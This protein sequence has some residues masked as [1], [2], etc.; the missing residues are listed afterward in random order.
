MN[1]GTVGML[2]TRCRRQRPPHCDPHR[3]LINV[4]PVWP[5]LI[6]DRSDPGTGHGA[7]GWDTTVLTPLRA[8]QPLDNVTPAGPRKGRNM[9]Q[10][11]TDL[12]T[13]GGACADQL[14]TRPGRSPAGRSIYASQQGCEEMS[15]CESMGCEET[16]P[17]R[18]AAGRDNGRRQFKHTGES[19]AL[20][21][22]RASH[23]PCSPNGGGPRITMPPL[24]LA[25]VMTRVKST[26][27][28]AGLSTL[29]GSLASQ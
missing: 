4:S 13:L 14:R 11:N 2:A 26:V 17:M 25:D 3:P 29:I 28:A 20:L 8:D 12:H 24:L 7:R 15:R 22:P 19:G 18:F 1:A 9:A 21:L 5:G 23:H 16:Q 10:D 27:C 6:V